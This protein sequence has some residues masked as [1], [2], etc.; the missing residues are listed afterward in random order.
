MD[1]EEEEEALVVESA[2]TEV[3]VTWGASEELDEVIPVSVAVLVV[4][5]S[6]EVIAVCASLAEVLS[7]SE[8]VLVASLSTVELLVAPESLEELVMLE[9]ESMLVLEDS[10]LEVPVVAAS[11]STALD[12]LSIVVDS[13]V[14]V[15]LELGAP[16]SDVE[17]VL[18]RLV[19]TT[20][21]DDELKA[22]ALEDRELETVACEEE[23]LLLE[24]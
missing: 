18:L 7:A 12:V 16:V 8:E 15:E 6:E 3:E 23:L 21:G 13:V 1:A 4:A 10:T 22:T 24:G 17:I 2:S 9:L 19:T 14:L 5:D 20:D 11:V